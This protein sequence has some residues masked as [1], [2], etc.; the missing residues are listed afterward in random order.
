MDH[1]EFTEELAYDCGKVPVGSKWIVASTGIWQLGH[2]NCTA[3]L[4]T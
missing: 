4:K 3:S 2:V 1:V